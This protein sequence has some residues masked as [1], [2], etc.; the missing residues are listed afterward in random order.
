MS[1]QIDAQNAGLFSAAAY[2]PIGSATDKDSVAVINLGWH[3]I[4]NFDSDIKQKSQDGTAQ[5]RIFVNDTT[6]EAVIAFKGSSTLAD[7][8][9]D[10]QDSGWTQYQA[11]HDDALAAR[12]YLKDHLSKY[13]IYSV[14]HSLGGGMAQSFAL[15]FNLDGFAQN[16]LP[17][18]SGFIAK[19]F[20]NKIIT[21]VVNL[22]KDDHKF[23]I[24]N[25]SG[26]IATLKYS[27]IEHQLYIATETITLASPYVAME[28]LGAAT[29]T[30]GGAV[31]FAYAGAKAHLLSTLNPLAAAQI[32]AGTGATPI[33]AFSSS[34][35]DISTI[36]LTK[37]GIFKIAT[38]DG[39]EFSISELVNGNGT[40]QV[41]IQGSN[42]GG[43]IGM[44]NTF[45]LTTGKLLGSAIVSDQPSHSSNNEI[46]DISSTIKL[47]YGY[48][49]PNADMGMGL[50]SLR[51]YSGVEGD[52][53]ISALQNMLYAGGFRPQEN[54][55]D[56]YYNGGTYTYSGTSVSGVDLNSMLEGKDSPGRYF[57]QGDNNK[58]T[59][60]ISATYV[61]PSGL[62]FGFSANNDGWYI[63]FGWFSPIVLDLD[64]DGVELIS[65][66][67]SQAY[68]DMTGNGYR[69]HTG[70][71]GAD[72]GLLVL[73]IDHDGVIDQAK[74]VSFALWTDNTQ[75]TDLEGLKA[76]FDNNHDNVIDSDD[77]SFIGL[78][79][80]QDA[81]GNGIS[82]TGELKTLAEL[83]ITAINLNSVKTDWSS[84]GNTINGFTTYDKVSLDSNGNPI[85]SQGWVADAA[86]SYEQN[87]WT[88]SHSNGLVTTTDSGGLAFATTTAAEL[89]INLATGNYG[90]AIGTAGNDSL[91]TTGKVAVFLEGA[92]GNDTLKGG[93]GDDWLE[94][95]DGV[96]ELSGG[97]GDDTLIIDNLD[98]LLK[99]DGGSGFDT[100][101]V[102]GSQGVTLNLTKA[103]IEVAVGS[104]GDDSFSV[105]S[106]TT[107]QTVA[108]FGKGGNDSLV[109]G[110]RRDIL[111][112]GV[113]QDTLTGNYGND[114]YIYSRGDGAD[115][116]V[117][118][119]SSATSKADKDT[120]ILGDDIS[121]ADVVV[122]H[123]GNDLLIGIKP[124]DSD[125]PISAVTDQEMINFI[126]SL[127]DHIVIQNWA[128]TKYKVE[129]I[130]FSDGGVYALDNWIA[131]SAVVDSGTTAL[132][133]TSKAD[134][135]SGGPGG[136]AMRGGKGNDAY[137]VDDQDDVVIELNHQG[138]DTVFSTITYTL[139]NYVENIQLVGTHAIDASGNS[140]DNSLTGNS[141]NNQLTGN[142]GDDTLDG[143]A[144]VDTLV[145]GI[146]DDT[147]KVD[148]VDD[149][150]TEFADEGTDTVLSFVST[151]TLSSELEKLTL[152]G[153]ALSGKGNASDNV[154]TGNDLNNSIDGAAG[155]DTLIGGLGNDTYYIDSLTDSIVEKKAEG[156]DTVISSLNYTLGKNLENVTLSEVAGANTLIALNASGNELGNAITGN[157][158]DNKLSGLAGNDTLNGG[159]GKDTMLGGTGD[160]VYVVD[161]INDVVTELSA[162]GSDTVI[163][164][165]TFYTLGNFIEN[166]TLGGTGVSN[167]TGN[168]LHNTIIG[169]SAD[170][171][172]DGGLGNDILNG[173]TGHDTMRGGGGND[174]YVVGSVGDVVIETDAVLKTG[175]TDIVYSDIDYVLGD[176]VENLVLTNTVNISGLQAENAT[177][178]SLNN[179]VYGNNVDNLIDG[180]D[181]KDSMY[182]GFG[183]DVYILDNTA[184]KVY[185]S[186]NQGIDK[187]ISSVNVAAL[188]T[189]VEN[190]ALTG[191]ATTAVGNTSNNL[192]IGNELSNK[193]SASSGNDT[194]VGGLGN[195]SLYG[196]TGNDYY[197]LERAG[198][199][200]GEASVSGGNDTVEANFNYTLG[201]YLENLILNEE[202]GTNGQL[203]LIGT[204]NS[205]SNIL[206]GN[207]ANN[208]LVGAKG[209]DTLDGKGG[210]DY[211]DGG[212]GNDTYIVDNAADVIVESSIATEIDSVMSS[213]DYT[214]QSN[215]ENLSLTGTAEISGIGNALNNKLIGNMSR[216]HLEGGAGNDTL[217]GGIGIDTLS[218]GIGNDTYIVDSESDVVIEYNFADRP[219]GTDLVQ[220]SA[221]T[222]TLSA[223]LEN[224]T[225]IGTAAIDGVGNNLN[226]TIIGN[227]AANK[228]DGGMGNDILK[229]GMGDDVYIVDSLSDVVGESANQGTDTIVTSL[230]N[231]TIASNVENLTLLGTAV[232][233]KG[234][235]ISN[236]IQGN[237]Q[238][239][240]LDGGEGNDSLKGDVG[241]DT[242]L[243]GAGNDV[244]NGG[245]GADS[246]SGGAGNDYYF[247]DNT[248][249]VIVE[250]SG[251]D[252]VESSVSYTLSAAI[253][254]LILVGEGEING[255]GNIIANTITGNQQ[256]NY[257]TGNEGD[258]TLIGGGGRDTL[259]GGAGSDYFSIDSADDLVIEAANSGTD[260]VESTISY[261]LV[262]N[263]EHLILLGEEELDATGNALA[264]QMTGNIANNILDGGAGKDTMIGGLG[265]D[266]YF[267]DLGSDVITENLDE[268]FD[269]VYSSVSYT[270]S[271]NIENLSLASSQVAADGKG[272]ASDNEITGNDFYNYLA[273]GEGNDTLF[274]EGGADSLNGGAGDDYLY[275]GEAG[276]GVD[277]LRGGSGND[278]YIINEATDILTD[279][280]SVSGENSGG[281]D[282]VESSVSYTLRTYF[283]DLILSGTDDIDGTGNSAAN[284]ILGNAGINIMAGKDGDDTYGV[285]N[286][287]DVVIEIASD[288]TDTIMSTITYTL[289]ANVENLVL[290]STLNLDGTGNSSNNTLTG[291]D[292][293]NTLSGLAGNDTL[294]GAGGIDTLLGGLGNDTYVVDSELDVVIEVSGEGTDIV[295]SKAETYTLSSNVENLTLIETG[296]S[297]GIGNE[298]N[299]IIR[300]NVG[301]NRLDG[302]AGNDTLIG[303]LGDDVY[304][305][306][307]VLDD[308]KETANQG[309]DEVIASVDYSLSGEYIENLTLVG[310]AI[311]GS[312]NSLNN[313]IVGNSLNNLLQGSLGSD[314]LD[315][316][317]GADTLDGGAGNDVFIVD[318]IND[319]VKENANDTTVGSYGNDTIQATIS[320]TLASNI[321]NLTLIGEDAIN[322][323]GNSASNIMIGNVA[324]NLLTGNAGN[325]TLD[326]GG[327][328]DTLVGG[329]GNDTYI[330]DSDTDVITEN[331]G[332]G[333]DAV[334]ST[335]N[336]SLSGTNLE[337]LTLLGDVAIYATGNSGN[338]KLTG[339]S[340]DNIFDGVGGTDTMAGGAGDDVYYIDS[341]SDIV[342]ESLEEGIDTINSTVT[343]TLA[344]NV[345]NLILLEVGA[346]NGTGNTLNNYITGNS[347]VNKLSGGDGNDTLDG[348]AGADTLTGGN[349]DDTFVIDNIADVISEASTGGTDTVVTSISY[350]LG[351]YLENLTLSGSSTVNGTGNTLNNTI[352]GNDANNTLSGLAGN[353]TL[354]GGEGSDT[355][356]GGV[357]DDTYIVDSQSDVVQ[358][359]AGEG[360]DTIQTYTS[361]ALVAN[362][363]NLTL[364][365]DSEID[366]EGNELNNI[367]TG[368]TAS[369]LLD[370]G[371]GR[372]TM[373]GGQG[374]DTYIVDVDNDVIME[375]SS[376]G[377]DTVLSLAN[378]TLSSNVENLTLLGESGTE[379][380]NGVGNEM[381]NVILGNNGN[382]ILSGLD[383]ND[384]LD[385]GAGAD[386]L[387][388]GLGDDTYIV[389]NST[390]FVTENASEGV[391]TVVTSQSYTLGVNFENLNLGLNDNVNVI[392]GTGNELSNVL[393]GNNAANTLNGL[394]GNNTLTGGLGDDVFILATSGSLDTI[395]DFTIGDDHIWLEN[396][397]FTSFSSTGNLQSSSFRTGQGL[398]SAQDA[399]D[400]LIYDSTTGNLYYDA[401]GNAA[402]SAGAVQIAQLS[403]GLA[404]TS[405]DFLIV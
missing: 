67:E 385:G 107:K 77:E 26:D 55:Q 197:V 10:I 216:N 306:D 65:R 337:N 1:H 175:G 174:T 298:L 241:N 400:Y 293:D 341:S 325:D 256:A 181:G 211:M 231:Y 260:T 351:L 102:T 106:P 243:G 275:A 209:N 38:K 299:N 361:L 327:G 354:D 57:F 71:V 8:Q 144:G 320:W 210:A 109:G 202:V 257:L 164:N 47:L 7:F 381:D 326:G 262:N 97:A 312:G 205:L 323:T 190:L 94:G 399:D 301:S 117:E 66:D 27:T 314:T 201:S 46:S 401:L 288:G 280:D 104:D 24:T 336:F 375:N 40:V 252:T 347:Y 22:Y 365:G 90:G 133:G 368:N 396:G 124:V 177:G 230:D 74:E 150:V 271:A 58:G 184:D 395:S 357:G 402:G 12:N 369:N 225:L 236:L 196:G 42:V 68:F 95:G 343:L 17:V 371:L 88:T 91:I 335:I 315:G 334:E 82:E 157:S 52:S 138:T 2:A 340:A 28:V 254:D 405:N 290:L 14:G 393:I 172:L 126:L 39:E 131:G 203:A 16:S 43:E 122:A 170:N 163:S 239:N 373:V 281:K 56:Y 219:S 310:N 403:A 92:A 118:R 372:D 284:V 404:L 389:S 265:D 338:N 339:N 383:G 37:D 9:S 370:G 120:L 18:S 72:D 153:Q 156:T 250:A 200:I 377:T 63:S 41:S 152:V 274:G 32:K 251:T 45:D 366:G 345:E 114:A 324:N 311:K 332:E 232:T 194:L 50:A 154:I 263:V 291:N 103:H 297:E 85:V 258:D 206:V 221:S 155:H 140:L 330:I 249:D 348:G 356:N 191:A 321:E 328:D 269:V 227:A 394:G 388:G 25:V 207:S 30:Y 292:A 29:G 195:D 218:G 165:L 166:L 248:Q 160:D 234:N 125:V 132:V 392:D 34:L 6:H 282:T 360:V 183:D 148:N 35:N 48:V 358:E 193:L 112:G 142:E 212:D 318:N 96:D 384:T 344:A 349:G 101:V 98:N 289:G 308:V 255:T 268:G 261:S 213:I 151:Y 286:E 36:E 111:E 362:V 31:L 215:L 110:W 380:L 20:S 178:N 359:L 135:L 264:N 13:K 331:A 146:G 353:D 244:M 89:K 283:E 123:S 23:V 329:V 49:V 266:T 259:S 199:L 276:D 162:Q 352:T 33:D 235:S 81:N 350:T 307:G 93:S 317:E 229:G 300:G 319:L 116:I 51:S 187:V 161:N 11:I 15:E 139:S 176:N 78:R 240:N 279:S 129:Y 363:E 173:K 277:T 222:Y 130:G 141:A 302:G 233:G 76:T 382:N 333:T 73:D 386:T 100:L 379:N 189:N 169:N 137:V 272:N 192:I 127:D 304:I 273:G 168:S 59:E 159:V 3:E 4:S 143:G 87:S 147:F 238:S 44:M 84:G 105:A 295:Q 374:D 204:G 79:I 303:G 278:Y 186:A 208:T 342:T 69:N 53:E 180:L 309:L 246:M 285:D 185:E 83:G 322:G 64:G 61:A 171:V 70:W 287:E 86:F 128:Q 223:Y 346:I 60:S 80:W 398:T 228:L 378:Y 134:V 253:E 121:L 294:D 245:A 113:G 355:M 21:D 247:V 75:D 217:D 158:L 108:L 214:L 267:V 62:A 391:D 313:L 390:V 119:L 397:T 220:S 270:L 198:D 115:L 224:L 19:Y 316:G 179:A 54:G 136:D 5:Y 242:L 182:G 376:E 99:L 364:I 367:L 237:A 145:G 188:A 296:D 149:L 387:M 226:N 305:V 167:G